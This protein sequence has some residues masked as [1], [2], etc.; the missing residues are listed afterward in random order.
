MHVGRAVTRVV[1]YDEHGRVNGVLDTWVTRLRMRHHKLFNVPGGQRARKWVLNPFEQQSNLSLVAAPPLLVNLMRREL[2]KEAGPNGKLITMPQELF[3]SKATELVGIGVNIL[4]FFHAVKDSTKHEAM[5]VSSLSKHLNRA[6][7]RTS[8][9]AHSAS[10]TRRDFVSQMRALKEPEIAKQ[11]AGHGQTNNVAGETY[12]GGPAAFDVARERGGEGDDG[13]VAH[14]DMLRRYREEE[15]EGFAMH[16]IA[17]GGGGGIGA[18]DVDDKTFEIV[19]GRRIADGTGKTRKPWSAATLEEWAESSAERRGMKDELDAK[20]KVVEELAK[21]LVPYSTATRQKLRGIL[22]GAEPDSE[23]GR[24]T[25]RALEAL[26]DV[27]KNKQ[28]WNS[29]QSKKCQTQDV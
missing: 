5:D 12:G 23:L 3:A 18:V 19:V 14:S 21:Q 1:E 17:S 22:D 4:L 9:P 27:L 7:A 28:N 10:Y 13:D 25:T 26:E 20:V 24:A 16:A 29:Q 2:L 6:S 15:M 11:L 8:M